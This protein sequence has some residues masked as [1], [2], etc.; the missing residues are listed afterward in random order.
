MINTFEV[1]LE[2]VIRFLSQANRNL[3]ALFGAKHVT[4]IT[5]QDLLEYKRTTLF[6]LTNAKTSKGDKLGFKTGIMYLAPGKLAGINVC[7]WASP[8]CL[9]ACLSQAG[10]GKF[11]GTTRARIIKT[12][13]LNTRR[14]YFMGLV[15]K[16]INHLVRAAEREGMTPIV[17]LNGTSDLDFRPIIKAN[18]TI[19]HYDYTKSVMKMTNPDWNLPNYHLTFSRAES[20]QDQTLAAISAGSNVAAVFINTLPQ[21]YLGRPVIDG[22]LTDLRFT[23][24]KGVIVGLV[25]KG[26][27]AQQD[28]S[29]FIIREA[30]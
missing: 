3:T 28:Q 19:Q 1:S 8:G 15:Q 29:G 23:D 27:K 6:D 21:T 26:P 9:G 17:R 18:P 16:S 5:L 30:V 12:L 11:Y 22:T 10:H 7:P 2:L 20:N 24:P 4:P 25:A 13:V 14:E